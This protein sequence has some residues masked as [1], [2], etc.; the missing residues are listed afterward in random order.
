[1]AQQPHK[2][3]PSAE[4]AARRL[5]I[6]RSVVIYGLT[7]PPRDMIPMLFENWSADDRHKFTADSEASREEFW[8]PLHKAGLWRYLSPIERELSEAT[9]VTMTHEQQINAT[10]RVESVLVLLWA[11]GLVSEL[12]SY[13]VQTSTDILKRIPPSI[14]RFVSS[15]SLRSTSEIERAR[16]AAELWHWRSRTRQ[17]I[18]DGQEFTADERLKAAGLGSY[19]D[20]VRFTAKTLEQEGRIQA[21]DEDFPA[22]GKAYRDL[23]DDE[24]S[25]VRSIT[26]ERHF[27]LNWL[28]GYAP[29]N[30]WDQTPADT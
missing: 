7:S 18:E 5:V 1:M 26:M 19:D 8:Q 29:D 3:P 22:K 20:I 30:E 16:D 17:L 27:A 14:D 23:T 9:A 2:T 25:E 13:D 11:A 6:L 10:W 28:C 15:A 24:W 12:A 4:D 21:I